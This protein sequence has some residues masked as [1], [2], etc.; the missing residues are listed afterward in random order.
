MKSDLKTRVRAVMA[1]AFEI[2]P[3]GLSDASDIDSVEQWDS[4]RHLAL[5]EAL[6]GEFGIEIG[7]ADAVNLS[8]VK[9]I[10]DYLQGRNV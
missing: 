9:D 10:L 1:G 5:V 3:A 8:S 7:H 4:L 6:E 2:D